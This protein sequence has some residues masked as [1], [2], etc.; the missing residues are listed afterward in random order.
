MSFPMYQTALH[1]KERVKEKIESGDIC[2]GTQCVNTTESTYKTHLGDL[3]QKSTDIT[4]IT[5]R[6]IPLQEIRQRLLD[7]HEN[8]GI[9]RQHPGEYTMQCFL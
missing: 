3:I 5:T 6:K 9:I 7:K 8:L 4:D 2:I 1:I